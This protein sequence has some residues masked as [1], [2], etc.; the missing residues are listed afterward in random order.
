[1]SF[2]WEWSDWWLNVSRREVQVLLLDRF[3]LDDK[4]TGA[5]TKICSPKDRLLAGQNVAV[6]DRTMVTCKWTIYLAS[7]DRCKRMPERVKVILSETIFDCFYGVRQN[8]LIVRREKICEGVETRHQSL[9]QQRIDLCRNLTGVSRQ[10][11][12]S[13][14]SDHWRWEVPIADE[15]NLETPVADRWWKRQS[16]A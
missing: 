1:M 16:K 13:A 14:Q 6:I 5:A 8:D 4:R 2:E 15:L 7:V 12:T 3:R 10:W 11:T 9:L